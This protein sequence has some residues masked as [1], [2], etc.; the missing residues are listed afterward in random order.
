MA[1]SCLSTV[2][3]IMVLDFSR[4][5]FSLFRELVG[6]NQNRAKGQGKPSG[7]E[8]QPLQIIMIIYSKVQENTTVAGR[9]CH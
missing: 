8:G 4:V 5:G 3:K 2:N 9:Q 1:V 6:R 7:H